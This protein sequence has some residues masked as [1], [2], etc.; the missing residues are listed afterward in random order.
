MPHRFKPGV[1]DEQAIERIAQALADDR[2]ETEGYIPD[3]RNAYTAGQFRCE[4]QVAW[5]EVK[6]MVRESP[7]RPC[8]N[9]DDHYHYIDGH[10]MG[11]A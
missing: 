10:E 5:N 3:H 9:P 2:N 11:Q 6:A 8:L 1:T 7:V 4:A